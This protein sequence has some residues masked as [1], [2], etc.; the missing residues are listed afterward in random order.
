MICLIALVV[1]GILGIFSAKYRSIAKEA[2]NCVFR[3]MTLRTC[4]TG[5]D[6]KMRI[7]IVGKLMT[8]S[9]MAARFVNTRFEMISW[10][11]TILMIVSFAYS[12]QAVYNYSVYGSCDPHGGVCVFNELTGNADT[13]T[14]GSQHCA[15]EGCSCGGKEENCTA[16]N[17]YLAC[18][19]N[20]TC[21]KTVCG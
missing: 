21:N 20:C 4:E 17:N 6:Q 15:D 2:F 16:A 11:F 14:C 13:V 19:G 3:R 1:F 9:T 18:A 10:F 5:F 12:A 7:Q 8:R